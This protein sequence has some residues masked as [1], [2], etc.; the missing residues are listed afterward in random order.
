MP[1]C[2]TGSGSSRRA[3]TCS[4]WEASPPGPGPTRS[5]REEEARRVLPVLDGLR[6]EA[7]EAVLSVDTRTSGRRGG[8]PGR[9]RRRRERRQRRCRSGDV[10]RGRR[11]RV[12]GM[13]LM[14][15]RGEPKTMQADPH[16]DD[17]VGGGA[18]VPRRADRGGGRGRDRPRPPLR[19]PRDRVRE[20]PRAQPRAPPLDRVVPRARRARARRSVAQAV[21]RRALGRGRPA[22]RLEGSVAAAVW[23]AT[24][25]VHVVRVHDVAPTV[26]A[27]R[28]ADAIARA[29]P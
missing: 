16:Y 20:E 6:R 17:V 24:Q 1:R 4:T 9:R 13:V 7:P 27:L 11:E 2:G 28:V 29:R 25:G 10:R 23:C 26:R 5:M 14:H 22:D 8:R 21:H 12:P 15:M 3:P 18:R 19:R